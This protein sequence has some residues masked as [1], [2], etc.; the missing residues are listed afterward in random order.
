MKF[1]L[2]SF[3]ATALL[4]TALQPHPAKAQAALAVE[5]PLLGKWQWTRKRNQCT[6]V[7]DFRSDGTAPIVSGTERTENVFTVSAS[8]EASGLYRLTVRTTRHYGGT[9][10]SDTGGRPNYKEVTLYVFFQT[11]D[12]IGICYEPNT[13]RCYGPLQRAPAQ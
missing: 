1:P 13:R 12:R 4:L 10:C 8:P 9:D 11:P 2:L 7:Y 5:H 3:A 6:E